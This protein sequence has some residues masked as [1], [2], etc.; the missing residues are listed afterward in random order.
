MSR[1]YLAL[2]LH[3][4]LPFVRHPEHD[5]FLEEDWFFEAVTETYIPLIQAL[6][7]L[8]QDGVQS[9]LTLSISPTLTEMLDDPLLQSRALRYLTRQMELSEREVVRT[10]NMPEFHSLAIKYRHDFCQALSLFESRYHCRLLNAFVELQQQGIL[11]IITCPGTH[12]FMPFISVEQVRN[13]HLIM[14]R[15]LHEHHFHK[16]LRGLWLA[17][18]GYEPAMDSLIRKAGF[19]YIILDAHGLL[20]GKPRPPHGVFAPVKTPAGIISFGRDMESS[21]QV[22]NSKVGYPGDL[23]YREFYRDLGFEAP[24]EYIRP[25]LHPD[26]VRRNIGF[27]YYRIT[28]GDDLNQRAAYDPQKAIVRAYQHAGHFIT[29]RHQQINHLSQT[30]GIKPVIV[31]PY[32][33][34]LFGHWWHEGPVFLEQVMRQASLQSSSIH[35]ASLSEVLAEFPDPSI[36]EP[37]GS[38]WGDEGY[39]R[40]WLNENNQWIYRHQHWAEQTMVELADGFPDAKGLIERGLNQAAR[41]LLLAQSSDWAFHLTEQGSSCY[42]HRRFADHIKHFQNLRDGLLH[43]QLNPIYLSELE[44]KDNIFSA[45]DYRIFKSSAANKSPWSAKYP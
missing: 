18:C 5:P 23:H 44:K 9:R 10:R 42:A 30:L 32:D 28:G 29:Q 19:E 17:E 1:G 40:V 6:Q 15:A 39:Y 26:G 22:W 38:S 20:F 41:E 27:K 35:L 13:A 12:P 24:Y 3:A 4:H 2:V 11:E 25:F 43:N 37:T 45:L 7:R 33:A 31:S 8:V 14:A 34:E 21:R 16:Q 36:V